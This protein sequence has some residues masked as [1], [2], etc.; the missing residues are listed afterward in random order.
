M[1]QMAENAFDFVQRVRERTLALLL[2]AL[3][4]EQ[5]AILVLHARLHIAVLIRRLRARVQSQHRSEQRGANPSLDGDDSGADRRRLRHDEQIVAVDAERL[6][7]LVAQH[8]L[9]HLRESLEISQ[10]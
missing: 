2:D 6:P 4:E 8:R 7:E 10:P 3:V 1:T 9:D 5:R